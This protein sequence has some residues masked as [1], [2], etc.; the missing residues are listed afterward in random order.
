M[1]EKNGKEVMEKMKR[2]ILARTK[3]ELSSDFVEAMIW[4][5]TGIRTLESGARLCLVVLDTFKNFASDLS[6]LMKSNPKQEQMIN[7]FRDG[8]QAQL[9]SIMRVLRDVYKYEMEKESSTAVE[10]ES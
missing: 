4:R 8:F 1:I 6:K 5:S 10:K 2:L 7:K 9:E 3:L